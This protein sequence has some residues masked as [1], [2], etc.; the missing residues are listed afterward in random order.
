VS[1]V[2]T[3]LWF[4]MNA[5]EATAFYCSLVPNSRVTHVQSYGEQGPYPADT[6]LTVDFELDGTSYVAINGGP[7][8][9]LTEAV[10]LQVRCAGQEEVDHYWAALTADGGREGPCGWLTDRFG[11]SWQVTPDEMITMLRDPDPERASRATQ[12]MYAMTKIDIA[13]MRAAMDG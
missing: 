3:C 1:K 13:A 11:L 9:P 10:S 12:A 4:D 7:D 5:A 6:V 2:S 8:H